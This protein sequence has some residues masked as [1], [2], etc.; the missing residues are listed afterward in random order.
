MF[1][2][3]RSNSKQS[4]RSH[5]CTGSNAQCVPA[6]APAVE[7]GT[8]ATDVEAAARAIEARGMAVPAVIALQAGRPL[9]WLGGQLLWVLQPFFEGVGRGK[10]P[11][12]GAVS[13]PGVAHLL[14]QQGAVE[15]L[16]AR[17]EAGIELSQEAGR[18]RREGEK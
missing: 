13:V 10:L 8:P 14:E 9:S 18:G 11:G 4:S 12:L 2:P 1:F 16:V 3:H 5:K 7:P 17:L 6:A 15:R